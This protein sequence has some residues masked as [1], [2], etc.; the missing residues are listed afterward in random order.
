MTSRSRGHLVPSILKDNGL[1]TDVDTVG[2]GLRF[3]FSCGNCLWLLS[4][5]LGS[6]VS[7]HRYLAI[8]AAI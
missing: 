2:D 1:G 3:P 8:K 7:H 5:S 4:L 6:E